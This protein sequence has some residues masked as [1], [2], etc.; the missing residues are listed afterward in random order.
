MDV[1]LSPEIENRVKDQLAAGQYRDLNQFVETAVQYF[2]DQHRRS[3]QRLRALRRIG[4]GVDAAGL[5]ECVLV[6]SRE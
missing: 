5:Y 4:Q 6:P 2:L 1:N 3:Q